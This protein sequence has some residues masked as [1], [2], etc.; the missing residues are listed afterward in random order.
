MP[1]SLSEKVDKQISI[2]SKYMSG[3]VGNDT[4]KTRHAKKYNCY[5]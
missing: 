1:W 5:K 4:E 3:T 2:N